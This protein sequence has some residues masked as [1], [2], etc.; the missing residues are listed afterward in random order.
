M[1]P[2][3]GRGQARGNFTDV[4]VIININGEQYENKKNKKQHFRIRDCN[5]N[6]DIGHARVYLD[7]LFNGDK[8]LADGMNTF[9]NDNWRTVSFDM[10]PAIEKSIATIFMKFF[11]KITNVFAWDL[12]LPL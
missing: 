11:N 2:I 3:I 4:N 12:L 8:I 1:L 10:K 6:L 5:A 9:I 7:N